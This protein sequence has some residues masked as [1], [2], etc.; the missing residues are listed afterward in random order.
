MSEGTVTLL[1]VAVLFAVVALTLAMASR[2][3]PPKRTGSDDSVV[4]RVVEYFDACRRN[5]TEATLVGMF[6]FV[7]LQDRVVPTQREVNQALAQSESVHVSRVDG[8]V[9]F[10]PAGSENTV[11]AKDMDVAYKKYR[12]I[13]KPKPRQVK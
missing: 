5:T 3:Q 2:G 1:V 13:F 6:G 12:R 8:L 7:E 4:A 11:T 9:H 10:G